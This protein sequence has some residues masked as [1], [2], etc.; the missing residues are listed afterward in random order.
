MV[1]RAVW[2]EATQGVRLIEH[3]RQQRR[4][5]ASDPRPYPGPDD[6]G[7]LCIGCLERRIG[8]RL[9]ADDFTGCPLNTDPMFL[10]SRRL[11]AALA[12]GS[13]AATGEGVA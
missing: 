10:R 4:H 7:F 11:T 9:V 2:R 1:T 6:G 3:L 12:H 13:D 8:R 5:P